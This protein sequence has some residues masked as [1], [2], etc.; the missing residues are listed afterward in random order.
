[1]GRDE[2]FLPRDHG[3]CRRRH[4]GG[5]GCRD[6]LIYSGSGRCQRNDAAAVGCRMTRRCARCAAEWSR[7]DYIGADVRPDWSPMTNKLQEK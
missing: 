4:V 3:P 5:Y 2:T 7:C 1:M 6:L